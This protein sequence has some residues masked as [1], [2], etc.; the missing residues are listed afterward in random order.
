MKLF[1]SDI[2]NRLHN[3]K[4]KQGG[5]SPDKSEHTF[6][7]SFAVRLKEILDDYT[8]PRRKGFTWSIYSCRQV[9]IVR[10]TGKSSY[11]LYE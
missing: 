3:S 6:L 1:F 8:V 5:L 4:E 11:R 7:M 9:T 10:V 2:L